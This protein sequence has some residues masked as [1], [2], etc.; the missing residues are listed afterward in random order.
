MAEYEIREIPSRGRRR[1]WLC[2]WCWTPARYYL[3]HKVP[4]TSI[5]VGRE[6]RYR[7]CEKHAR[8]DAAGL[9]ISFPG[10]TI[11]LPPTA[12]ANRN[13]IAAAPELLEVLQAMVADEAFA[14]LCQGIG[15]EPAWLEM[16]R[17]AIAK[18]TGEG[19]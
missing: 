3:V 8:Q 1:G 4:P 12:V 16:A 7:R 14:S 2:G 9:G 19:R 6:S 10:T 15:S 13:L 17:T 5:G 18:A 11:R